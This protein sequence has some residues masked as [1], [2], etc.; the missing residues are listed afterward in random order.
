ME[1]DGLHMANLRGDDVWLNGVDGDSE[2]LNWRPTSYYHPGQ[3]RHEA[4]PPLILQTWVIA[5]G[6]RLTELG[7]GVARPAGDPVDNATRNVACAAEVSMGAAAV[8]AVPV[9]ALG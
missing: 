2:N 7:L 3:V 9:S 8:Q 4:V 5:R 1:R 6:D